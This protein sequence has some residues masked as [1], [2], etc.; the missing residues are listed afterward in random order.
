MYVNNENMTFLFCKYKEERNSFENAAIF[1]VLWERIDPE[2]SQW[3]STGM[4][5]LVDWEY[6]CVF[7]CG[8]LYLYVEICIFFQ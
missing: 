3:N 2:S 6:R 8:N 7:L 1:Q 5:L 4:F